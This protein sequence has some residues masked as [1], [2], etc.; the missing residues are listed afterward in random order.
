MHINCSITELTFVSQLS[1][2]Q[3]TSSL[4][5]LNSSLRHLSYEKIVRRAECNTERSQEL[6]FLHFLSIISRD[7]IKHYANSIFSQR[8]TGDE[9]VPYMYV[10]LVPRAFCTRFSDVGARQQTASCRNFCNTRCSLL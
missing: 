4:G 10:F 7:L 3:T 9:S 6:S 2:F 1:I 5:V 8:M